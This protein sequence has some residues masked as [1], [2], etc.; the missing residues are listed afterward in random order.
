MSIIQKLNRITIEEYLEG[1]KESDL[2]HEYI[3]GEI[4]AMVG[5]SKLHNLIAGS[6]FA[7]FR[8]HLKDS[9]CN[10]FMSDMKVRVDNA[11][12]YPDI[13]V[14]CVKTDPD[15][16]YES[17]PMIIIE[18]L[19]PATEAR[20]RFE[21]RLAFQRLDSLKEYVLVSQ[22]RMNIEIYRRVENGWEMEKYSSSEVVHFSSIGL[23]KPI[24]EIYEDVIDFTG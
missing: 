14:S 6:L 8:A 7:S 20:D 1:E 18:V 22:D 16:Y 2:R 15:V 5:T 3:G 9:P 4:Y 11:F 10:V 12:Y 21:K 17:S 13:I 24:E 19:S 23:K